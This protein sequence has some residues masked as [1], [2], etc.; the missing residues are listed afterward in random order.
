MVKVTGAIDAWSTQH[1]IALGTIAVFSERCFEVFP[2]LTTHYSRGHTE[3]STAD[4]NVLDSAVVFT[5]MILASEAYDG[6]SSP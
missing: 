5:T 4:T 6:E 1:E 3:A 2:S